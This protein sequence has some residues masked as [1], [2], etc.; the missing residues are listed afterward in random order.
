[1]ITDLRGLVCDTGCGLFYVT[2]NQPEGWVDI[3]R[4]IPIRLG[5]Q[6][7][8]AWGSTRLMPLHPL[9]QLAYIEETERLEQMLA[10]PE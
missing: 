8:Q 3:V 10:L 4:T 6:R 1:M 9:L 5:D 7:P 2:Q